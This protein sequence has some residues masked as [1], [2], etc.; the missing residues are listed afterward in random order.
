MGPGNGAA[1]DGGSCHGALTPPP[2]APAIYNPGGPTLRSRGSSLGRE[3]GQRGR[4]MMDQGC[5]RREGASKAAPQAG[6][7]AVGGACQ[8]GS[9][10]LLSVTNAIEAGTWRQGDSGW[11]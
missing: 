9:G 8:S 1:L 2:R 11:A 4:Q 5:I 7:L 6:R 3:G 10:R